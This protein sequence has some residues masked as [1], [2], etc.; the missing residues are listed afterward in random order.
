V[1]LQV[2]TV[3]YPLADAQRALDDLRSGRFSG[4]AVLQPRSG[5]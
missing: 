1:P 4:A 2:H 3:A 5:R